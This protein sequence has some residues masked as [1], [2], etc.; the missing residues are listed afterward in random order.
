MFRGIYNTSFNQLLVKKTTTTIFGGTT[1]IVE[2]GICIVSQYLKKVNIVFSINS[3]NPIRLSVF[4]MVNT[5][6]TIF[7][8][9]KIL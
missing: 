9:D 6:P 5:L 4:M 2:D 3:I 1:A 8:A 7:S